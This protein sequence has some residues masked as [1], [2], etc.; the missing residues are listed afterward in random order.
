[1]SDR[2]MMVCRAARRFGAR[3]VF[4]RRGVSAIE[5]AL[6]LPMMLTLYI[7]SA[8][9]STGISAN[10]KVT[11]A[12]HTIA[13]LASEYTDITNAEMS[14]LLA[15]APTIMAPYPAADV[16]ATVSEIAVDAQG[17]ATVVWSDTLNGTALTVGQSVTVPPAL[18]VP[19]T[20]LILGQVQ[21]TYNPAYG[22]Y[23]TGTLNLSDQSFVHPRQSTSI[24]RTA[25]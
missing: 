21:Y 9:L 11:L 15:A 16:Q 22:S 18:A 1:M 14:N 10:R 17:A 3:F 24:A 2:A 25:S 5:F 8:E 7:G 4:D 20:Y 6:L 19:N 13:D 12:A 23:L